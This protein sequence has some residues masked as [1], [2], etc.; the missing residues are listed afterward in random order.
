MQEERRGGGRCGFLRFGVVTHS[1]QLKVGSS[2]RQL[3]PRASQVRQPGA[4][5]IQLILI[6]ALRHGALLLVLVLQ[7]VVQAQMAL[8]WASWIGGPRSSLLPQLPLLGAPLSEKKRMSILIAV[9][10]G[11]SMHKDIY[12]S[13]VLL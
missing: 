7:T 11:R 2:V 1:V 8:V 10:L 13:L 12:V 4:L 6:H 9:T 3:G 5:P